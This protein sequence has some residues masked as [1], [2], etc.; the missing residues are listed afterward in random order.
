MNGLNGHGRAVGV[1]SSSSLGLMIRML[2]RYRMILM[3]TTRVEFAKKYSGSV[4][5]LLWV[6]LNPFLLLALY[7]FVYMVIFKMRFPGFSQMDYVLYVFTGLIPYLGFSEALTSGTVSIKQNI[8]LVKNVMLPIE[9]IPVRVVIISMVTQFVG[10][11]V[12]LLMT[13]L[14][15]NLSAHILWLPAVVVLQLLFMVGLVWILSAL[16]VTLPDIGYFINLAMLFLLFVSPIGFKPEMVPDGFGFML[17]INP[18]YYMTEMY[19]D[20]MLFG[21]L[22]DMLTTLVYVIVSI[23]SFAAGSSFFRRFKNVLVDYE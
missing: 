1:L 23:G 13:A 16:A 7:L 4:L 9:L 22:P 21:K 5:G 8:H 18:I 19:R 12:L 6:F 3:A 14:N 10:M 20:S 2:H 11:G 17:Y 15:G